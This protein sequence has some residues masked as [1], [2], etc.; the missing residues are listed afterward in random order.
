MSGIVLSVSQP[1]PI[2]LE[3]PHSK[4]LLQSSDTILLLLYWPHLRKIAIRLAFWP[5]GSHDT[6]AYSEHPNA[7]VTPGRLKPPSG[8]PSASRWQNKKTV[9]SG[10]EIPE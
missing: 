10:P 6:N 8:S 7:P 9:I 3:F 5:R 4:K 1:V 2:D